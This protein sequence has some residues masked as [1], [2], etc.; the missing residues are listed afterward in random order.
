M[1]AAAA[2][3]PLADGG[4]D[5][6]GGTGGAAGAG[7]GSQIPVSVIQESRIQDG[8]SASEHWPRKSAMPQ[9]P[10]AQPKYSF[11][12]AITLAFGSGYFTRICGGHLSASENRSSAFFVVF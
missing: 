11:N 10:L 2:S 5:G 9:L 12:A 4:A 3:S 7:D 1:G 6:T 8:I